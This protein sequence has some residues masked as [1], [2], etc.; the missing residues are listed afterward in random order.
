VRRS[1][2]DQFDYVLVNADEMTH[3]RFAARFTVAPVTAQGR[4]RLYRLRPA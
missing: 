1:D 4:W 3:E 2:L